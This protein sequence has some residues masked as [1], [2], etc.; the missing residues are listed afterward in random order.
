M[1]QLPE[2]GVCA[3]PW[4]GEAR[5][6]RL[7]RPAAGA[8]GSVSPGGVA[9]GQTLWSPLTCEHGSPL[10]TALTAPSPALLR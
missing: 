7:G 10:D 9:P 6:A 8:G 1:F 4:M 5:S 2:Q 3:S